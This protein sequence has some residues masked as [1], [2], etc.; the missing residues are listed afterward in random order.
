MET[1]LS[2]KSL[3]LLPEKWEEATVIAFKTIL[4]IFTIPIMVFIWIVAFSEFPEK[5]KI[6]YDLA[7]LITFLILVFLIFWIERG[8]GNFRFMFSFM[9]IGGLNFVA[10]LV[11]VLYEDRLKEVL[12]EFILLLLMG[13]IVYWMWYRL[14]HP[15][16]PI[17]D[18]K[19]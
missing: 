9:V 1:A 17:K 14:S 7:A 3:I 12:P 10:F 15:L 2:N 5:T 19:D 16:R 18:L 11:K 6:G 13:I 4:S 8:R